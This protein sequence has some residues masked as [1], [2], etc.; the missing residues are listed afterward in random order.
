MNACKNNLDAN[1]WNEP[2]KNLTINYPVCPH[3]SILFY[4][5][6]DTLSAI[7]LSNTV[8]FPFISTA[9]K[10]TKPTKPLSTP[11]RIHPE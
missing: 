1:N 10:D 6:G 4:P 5:S 11:H 3:F 2:L 8:S 9:G 7:A